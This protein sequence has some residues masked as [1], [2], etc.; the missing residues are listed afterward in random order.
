MPKLPLIFLTNWLTY[1]LNLEIKPTEVKHRLIS[2]FL[3]PYVIAFAI[4]L[5]VIWL[6]PDYF[7][8]YQV[9]LDES[10]FVNGDKNNRVYFSDLDG[11]GKSEKII[12]QLSTTN[13]ASYVV[14]NAN[15]DFIDQFNFAGQFPNI[16]KKLWFQDANT[17]HIK[18]IYF[19]SKRN[20]S[21]FL[22]IFE[23]KDWSKFNPKEIY[24]DSI[25]TYNGDQYFG[26]ENISENE[27]FV[28]CEGKGDVVFALRAGFSC[29]PR[30]IYKYSWANDQI[31][32]SPYLANPEI[33]SSAFDLDQDGKLEYLLEGNSAGNTNVTKYS[34]RSDYSTWLTVLDDNLEFMFEPFE[35]K[36]TGNIQLQAYRR[37][38]QAFIVGYFRSNKPENIPSKYFKVNASGQFLR[39]IELPKGFY[40]LLYKID[41][42]TNA[43]FERSRGELFFYDLDLNFLKKLYLKKDLA[44]FSYDL[45]F[46]GKKEWI[47]L[48]LDNQTAT[49]WD[50]TFKHPVTFEFTNNEGDTYD[51]GIKMVGP[52]KLQLY[53]KK[54]N[55]LNLFSYGENPFY[56][57]KYVVY[58][59]IYGLVLLIIWLILKGHEL[60]EAKKR[61]IEQE[62]A[63]LQL[64][65]IKNQVD[66]HFV[67]NAINTI[68][69][70]TLMDNKLE[71]DRFIG[72]FS[73]LM[74]KTLGR[75]DKISTTIEDE[76]SYVENYLRLQ[77]IR[78]NRKFDYSVEVGK[79]VD[80]K[81]LIPKHV[82]Y[83][84]VENAVKYGLPRDKQGCIKVLVSNKNNV[85]I[86]AVED[87]G[88]GLKQ[89]VD[90]KYSTGT[91]LKVIKQ[92]FELYSKRFGVKVD[93]SINNILDENQH[94]LGTRAEVKMRLKKSD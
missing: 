37:H 38:S 90:P 4:A 18:E 48:Y 63:D 51:R 22:N 35:F 29:Y 72:E 10:E 33:V 25:A 67:F 75:S 19:I 59:G 78:Y 55:E 88:P 53:F 89:Q 84:F 66:P 58:L 40:T 64:K 41:E 80:T 13:S 86:M 56:F 39:E 20:D 61:M 12:A 15:G 74:R 87:N 60:R 73:N 30:K 81:E 45:N 2:I 93:H 36:S 42:H 85:L 31:I 83:T 62:I 94:I 9:V 68:S 44:L 91:G 16:S 57:F 69:E 43:F 24:V 5:F 54:G 27:A 6:I 26:Y 21:A 11:D 1:L 92:I 82:I 17:N 28:K 7:S 3:N 47:G 49:I 34:Q 32:A 8:K 65:T 76:L 50:D 77:Q 14:Y 70:M 46:D 23:P 79:D 71:A 52:K